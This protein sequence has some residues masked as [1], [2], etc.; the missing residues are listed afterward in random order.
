MFIQGKSLLYRAGVHWVAIVCIGLRWCVWFAMVCHG[1]QWFAV[2][3]NGL[4]CF[5][6]VC[7]CALVCAGVHG[8]KK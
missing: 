8:V 2:V 6:V 4:Q 3:C 5:V 1:L 7:W